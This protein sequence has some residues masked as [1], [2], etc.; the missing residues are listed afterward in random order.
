VKNEGGRIVNVQEILEAVGGQ[1]ARVASADAVIG[2]PVQLGPV[3]VYPISLVSVGFGGGAGEGENEKPE[4]AKK[5]HGPGSGSGGG[6]GGG[7]R[8]RPIA[9]L[10]LSPTG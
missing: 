4:Q 5:G 7:A 9:V 6:G 2:S 8:A 3:T 10:V 1:L